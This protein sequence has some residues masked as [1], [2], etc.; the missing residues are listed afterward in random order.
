MLLHLGV[1]TVAATSS[2]HN[3]NCAVP[4]TIPPTARRLEIVVRDPTHTDLSIEVNR[5]AAGFSTTAAKGQK[6]TPAVMKEIRIPPGGAD[7]WIAAY[8]GGAG[9]EAL[10]VWVTG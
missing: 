1:L 6:L 5:A 10:D 3:G 4:F 9:A 7:I 2:K 8:N